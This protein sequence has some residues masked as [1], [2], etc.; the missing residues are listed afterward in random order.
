MKNGPDRAGMA[1]QEARLRFGGQAAF[2]LGQKPK[3]TV[4]RL[5]SAT[6]TGIGFVASHLDRL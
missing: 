1:E 6:A 3:A 4:G 5:H 2:E